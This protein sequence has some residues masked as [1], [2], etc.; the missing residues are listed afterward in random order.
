MN[1]YIL[2]TTT[3]FLYPVTTYTATKEQE[4]Y[5]PIIEQ[6]L[7]MITKEHFP[8]DSHSIS[9]RTFFSIQHPHFSKIVYHHIRQIM[10]RQHQQEGTYTNAGLFP[11]GS[12][13]N[14][15]NHHIELSELKQDVGQEL[16]SLFQDSSNQPKKLGPVFSSKRHF[17]T[18]KNPEIV[19]DW[20]RM[21]A[22]MEVQ[23]DL[24]LEEE[25]V[26]SFFV[27]EKPISNESHITSNQLAAS[28]GTSSFFSGILAYFLGKWRKGKSQNEKEVELTETAP[29]PPQQ[30]SI[31]ETEGSGEVQE[32]ETPQETEG[33]GEV[34]ETTP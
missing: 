3:L 8:I 25:T 14:T 24:G 10:G 16:L 11:Y 22:L 31:Q 30:E 32:T 12:H 7:K 17:F 18:L 34:Q 19:T 2:L 23:K 5:P 26:E 1:K 33:F 20:H 29:E 15:S 6:A 4:T 13:F 28:A 21:M 27:R 9:T